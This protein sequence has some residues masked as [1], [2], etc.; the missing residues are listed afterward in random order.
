LSVRNIPKNYRNVTGVLASSK[1]EGA[2]MFEST[3]ER[4]LLMQLDFDSCVESYDVQPVKIEWLDKVGKFRSYT[5]DV[6]VHYRHDDRV[7]HILYEVK[8]RSDIKENWPILKPKF[9]AAI[10]YAKQRGWRFKLITEVEIRTTFLQN[11]KF[12]LPFL[13]RGPD[14]EADMLLIQEALKQHAEIA[15][16]ELLASLCH[17]PWSQAALIPTLWYLIA[18]GQIECEL[19]SQPLTMSS[20][21]WRVKHG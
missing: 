18:S 2:A 16:S 15:I 8:Y 12:L 5:P 10:R 20:V 17:N 21:I 3:L 1:S 19:Q 13:K 7:D 6:L 11:V 9:K 4:D 14:Q